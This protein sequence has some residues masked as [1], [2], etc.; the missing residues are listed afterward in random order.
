MKFLTIGLILCAINISVKAEIIFHQKSARVGEIIYAGSGCLESDSAI[1]T[2]TEDSF[3]IEHSNFR[4][5]AKTSKIGRKNCS[6]RIP[7][8]PSEGTQVAL[9]AMS[10]V[11]VEL[12]KKSQLRVARELFPVGERGRIVS[13]KQGETER[14]ILV[15]KKENELEFSECGKPTL[16]ALNQNLLLQTKNLN[17]KDFAEIKNTIVKVVTRPCK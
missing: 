2:I 11:E 8:E 5:D 10:L 16:L 17:L 4:V 3:Y 15:L 14:K 13:L 12:S 9:Q 7:V 6:M 1:R